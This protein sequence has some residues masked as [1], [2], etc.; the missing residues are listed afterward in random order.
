MPESFQSCE[1]AIWKN[2]TVVEFLRNSN[3]SGFILWGDWNSKIF[4][5]KCSFFANI[6][7]D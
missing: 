3:F 2:K 4:N 1:K 7:N 5:R 6:E